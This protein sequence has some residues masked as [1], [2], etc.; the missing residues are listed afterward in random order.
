M[1]SDADDLPARLKATIAEMLEADETIS[2]R[3]IMRRMPGDF[4]YPTSVSRPKELR[5]NYEKAVRHQKQIRAA[6]KSLSRTTRSEAE[7]RLARRDLPIEEL[8]QQVQLAIASHR[9]R[10]GA[11]GE[12]G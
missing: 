8:E 2:T 10:Y 7:A 4:T 3:N 6:A 12:M 9:A 5:P 1:I 11:V